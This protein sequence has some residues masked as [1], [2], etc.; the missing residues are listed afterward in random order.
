MDI[1][2]FIRQHAD[3]DAIV[4]ELGRAINM[5]ERN[6]AAATRWKL[7]RKLVAHLA[8]EDKLLYPALIASNDRETATL[9]HGM[10]AEMGNLAERFQSYMEKWDNSSITEQWSAFRDETQIILT[11]LRKRIS[12]E[13]HVVYPAY[14]RLKRH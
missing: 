8:L 9:A 14:E 5:D 3:I 4:T 7:A 6:L 13:N 10:Q 12:K 1:D 2:T 11:A